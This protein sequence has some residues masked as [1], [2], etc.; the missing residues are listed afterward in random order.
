MHHALLAHEWS[1]PGPIFDRIANALPRT[2]VSREVC[3]LTEA[4]KMKKTLNGTH[5]HRYVY[6]TYARGRPVI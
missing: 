5:A 2:T 3:V 6:W 1:R 4:I